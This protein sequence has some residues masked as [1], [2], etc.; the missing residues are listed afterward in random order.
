MARKCSV[1]GKVA[2]TMLY[3]ANSIGNSVLCAQCYPKISSYDPRETFRTLE[4]VEE[5][6]EKVLKEL[7]EN[8]FPESVKEDYKSF[9]QQKKDQFHVLDE[10]LKMITTTPTMEGY[11]IK[12]YK[13]FVSGEVVLGTGFLSSMESG[14]ADML[15]QESSTYK[16]KIDLAQEEA[17]KRTMKEAT[18]KGANAIV[19]VKMDIESFYAD[20][21]CILVTG[22]AVFVE[23]E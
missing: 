11:K 14:W 15:G 16:D 3:T 12:E 13:G 17:L 7:E 9:Y 4:Q 2:D 22:T 23:K 21:I 1:C 6:E 20:K 10:Q 8:D 19:G 5:K 18:N